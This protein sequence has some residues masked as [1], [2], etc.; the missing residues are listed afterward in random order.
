MVGLYLRDASA[1]LA[2]L[3]QAA[4][5]GDAHELEGAAHS[6]KGGSAQIGATAMVALCRDLETAAQAE[7][8][9]RAA[10]V[11]ATLEQTF[12]RVWAA[13]AALPEA[14]GPGPASGT[15]A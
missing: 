3:R 2:A 13:L 11:V 14:T 5:R 9:S 8:S 10:T 7:D 12:D 4:A 15:D 6:L 1:Q